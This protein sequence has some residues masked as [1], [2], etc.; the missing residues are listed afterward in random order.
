MILI[1]DD[2][3]QNRQLISRILTVE[4]LE[5]VTAITAADAF[6][7]IGL[8]P[9]VPGQEA[10]APL[11]VPDVILMDIRMPQMDG[12]EACRQLKASTH[13]AD[14]PVLMITAEDAP[15]NLQAAF[16]AGAMDFIAKPFQAQRVLSAIEKVV[17]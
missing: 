10:P 15:A 16:D 9:P 6:A 8:V 1:V 3:H 13:F 5:N 12:I 17:A 7:V 14:V 4:G 2:N 11:V